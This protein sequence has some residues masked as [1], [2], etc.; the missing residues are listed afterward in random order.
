[1]TGRLVSPDM[2]C[3]WG[4]KYIKDD[5]E[6]K[7]PPKYTYLI[8]KSGEKKVAF[9]DPRKFGSVSLCDNLAT[10]EELAPDGLDE[11]NSESNHL[12]KITSCV[13]N[14][15]LGIKALLLDQKRVVS[16]VGNWVADEV[17]YQCGIHPDQ[18][19]LTKE[20]ACKIVKKLNSILSTAVVCLNQYKAYP[21]TWL[22]SYRWTRKKA[23][24]DCK[25][26][27]LTFLQSGGRTSA[28]VA[29]IQKLRKSQ[30]KEIEKNSKVSRKRKS[31][32]RP[33]GPQPHFK[34]EDKS[35]VT[36][37][38]KKATKT[39]PESRLTKRRNEV[40]SGMNGNLKLRRSLRLANIGE[41]KQFKIA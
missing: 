1:M 22:F 13:S 6:A 39:L 17:L 2:S 29:S 38:R 8:L 5:E 34:K 32:S 41:T 30:G 19:N 35:I 36:N 11:T 18:Q 16:G 15:R 40:S 14:Q 10:A 12:E 23:G 3:S 20:Q 7:F 28:I 31:V 24:K 4:N 27:S 9:A 37:K 21:E 33:D 25:G 26:R